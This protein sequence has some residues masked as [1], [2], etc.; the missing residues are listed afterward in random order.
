MAISWK[1]LDEDWLVEDPLVA[2][3]WRDG[4]IPNDQQNL[5]DYLQMQLAVSGLP[6]PTS[7][8]QTASHKAMWPQKALWPQKTLWQSVVA[9]RAAFESSREEPLAVRA[10]ARSRRAHREFSTELL[11]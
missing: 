7:A 6:V 4:E 2:L 9:K 10:S 3:G 8:N 5:I 1:Q 11:W